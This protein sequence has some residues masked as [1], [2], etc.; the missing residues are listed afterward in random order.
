M[1][2]TFFAPTNAAFKAIPERLMLRLF[3][4]PR[5]FAAQFENLLLYHC[6]DGGRNIEDLRSNRNIESLNNENVTLRVGPDGNLLING[7]ISIIAPEE[8]L[9]NGIT[10]TIG[11][12]FTPKWVSTTIFKIVLEDND[13]SMLERFL[14]IARLNFNSDQGRVNPRTLLGPSNAAFQ[15]LGQEKLD[16]LLDPANK[17]ELVRILRY[18]TI[19][20]GALTRDNLQDVDSLKTR[21]S[22]DD[23]V[24]SAFRVQVLVA[25]TTI[26]FN[27]A[28]A[29]G[30]STLVFNGAFIKIDKVLNPDSDDPDVGFPEFP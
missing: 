4:G 14:R 22:D 27:Q 11:G 30:D 9:S 20:S 29:E 18:H 26:K 28:T 10:Q 7:G 2:F 1:N 15:A 8:I 24:D 21:L 16:S 6:L 12:V 5:L 17:A 13:L 23:Y 19:E 3:G 25:G